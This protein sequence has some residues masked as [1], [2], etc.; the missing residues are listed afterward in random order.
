[1]KCLDAMGL[2]ALAINADAARKTAVEHFR[3]ADANGDGKIT[4][5]EFVMYAPT[6]ADAQQASHAAVQRAR[7]AFAV[8]DVDCSGF[9]D[10]AEF[11]NCCAKMGLTANISQEDA[12]RSMQEHFK[13]AD[14][15]G[16]GV[17][18]ETEFTRIFLLLESYIKKK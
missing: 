16:R 15:C 5:N 11:W 14:I 1:M 8:L 2:F 10:Q 7:A 3:K 18:D 12:M 4:E 9:I 6:L 13:L 17:L